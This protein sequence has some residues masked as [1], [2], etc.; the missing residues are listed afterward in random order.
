MISTSYGMHGAD[1]GANGSDEAK[2]ARE[3]ARVRR[4]FWPKLQRHAAPK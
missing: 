1:T 4:D 2:A 3:E